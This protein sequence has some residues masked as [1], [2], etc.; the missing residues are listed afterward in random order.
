MASKVLRVGLLTEVHRLDPRQPPEFTSSSVLLQVFESPFSLPLEGRPSQPLVFAGPLARE[1]DAGGR[2]V[3][4]G[5]VRP[6]ITFSDGT[7]VTASHVVAS[8][9]ATGALAG[10]A[11]VESRG[12]RVLFTLERPNAR[13]HLALTQ[14]MCGVFLERGGRLLGT[15]P[16][17]IEADSSPAAVN[18]ARNERHRAPAALDG[19][20]FRTYAPDAQGRPEPLLAAIEANEV[21]LCYVLGRE[22]V[23][24]L[25]RVRKFI[26]PGSSTCLL[27]FN[28]RSPRLA[29]VEVRRALAHAIDR[30]ALAR[31][32]YSNALAFA[33]QGPLPPAVGSGRDGI[34]HD[35]ARAAELLA[36]AGASKPAR[37]SM[38]RVWG[39][40]PYL[41]D[42]VRVGDSLVEALG[43]LGVRVDV[44]PTRDADD[45]FRRIA[46]GDADLYLSG[47]AADT[48]D[49]ADYLESILASRAVP[50]G[51]RI[52]AH[53]N[54]S[55]YESPEM[56][57]ALA[58]YRADPQE[59]R[60]Q[61]VAQLLR[62]EAP[63][64]PLLYGAAILAHAW[65]VR[66]VTPSA[67]GWLPLGEV[68]LK[69]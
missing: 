15:G 41:A 13:F 37:L 69:D 64:L 21:D 2:M 52:A 58:A 53:G 63:L 29:S 7:P 40:R 61:E 8:L 32:S 1:A 6:G 60:W 65:R 9:E 31:I 30:R 11:E 22:D 34:E 18:L 39:P 66:N 55:R 4:S 23:S 24:R 43:A 42:P 46:A 26:L 59:G 38:L 5:V 56:D 67:F 57:A 50:R 36:A 27:Y 45:Y 68:D 47:W 28:T 3:W 19:V 49:P 12:E 35:A 62:D 20:Q 33:A 44:I 48:P 25:T 14:S 54:L 10:Q 51:G 17:A 16:F